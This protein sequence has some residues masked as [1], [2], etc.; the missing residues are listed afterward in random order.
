MRTKSQVIGAVVAAVLIA[1]FTTGTAVAQRSKTKPKHVQRNGNITKLE[2]S[3]SKDGRAIV[4]QNGEIVARFVKG[5]R[6]Q[7]PSQG[8]KAESQNMQGVTAQTQKMQG[9]LRCRNE[10]LIYDSNGRCVRWYRSCT[11]DFDCK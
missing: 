7:M 11:W 6:V 8:V 9:C 4:D 3:I 1:L 10:C 5:M 2:L